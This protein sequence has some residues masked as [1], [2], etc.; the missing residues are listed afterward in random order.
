MKGANKVADM[1]WKE[2]IDK[3]I[4]FKIPPDLER[5][6]QM[7]KTADLRYEF[8][9]MKIKEK[10]SSLKVEAYYEIIRDLIFAH[11]YK[12]GFNC[13]NHLCLI[14]FLKENFED[15]DFEIE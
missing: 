15:F 9:D 5:A 4:I 8:W 12:N 2:C 13:T 10:F 6:K 11:L 1:S 7:E 3:K 14:S